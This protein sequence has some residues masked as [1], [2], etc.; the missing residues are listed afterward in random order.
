MTVADFD[1]AMYH[2]SN[3]NPEDTSKILISISVQ[4]FHQ[5]K[6]F[7]VDKVW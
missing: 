6:D 7:D 3:P 4:F 1:G 5:L 2:I